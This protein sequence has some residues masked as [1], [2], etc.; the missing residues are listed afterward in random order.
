MQV[1]ANLTQYGQRIL[2]QVLDGTHLVLNS[3]AT[4]FGVA[5]LGAYVVGK[6]EAENARGVKPTASLLIMGGL[7]GALLLATG[8][9][10][11][12]LPITGSLAKYAASH[13]ALLV[14]DG[15]VLGHLAVRNRAEH[16]DSISGEW[17]WDEP[18]S[19]VL[20]KL[21]LP[22]HLAVRKAALPLV[23]LW[24]GVRM[25]DGFLAAAAPANTLPFVSLIS[26][27]R[28]GEAFFSPWIGKV[29][30]FAGKVRS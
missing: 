15:Y 19:K 3:C 18:P 28:A 21:G 4:R 16:E 20:N 2:P 29:M 27:V 1:L 11:G 30:S 26:K 14:A 5:A 12:R 23:A 22:E 25:Y 7:Y 9:G 13:A 6:S 24:F 10:A 17:D 8:C